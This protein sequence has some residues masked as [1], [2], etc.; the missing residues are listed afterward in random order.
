MKH[1]LV[2]SRAWH[3][4]QDNVAEC[5]CL[6][7]TSFMLAGCVHYSNLFVSEWDRH[8]GFHMQRNHE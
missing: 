4:P 6:P 5:F 8:V 1:L 7:E 3:K 2:A